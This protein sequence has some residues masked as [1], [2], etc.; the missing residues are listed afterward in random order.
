MHLP[1]LAGDGP[2]RAIDDADN[3]SCLS[4][5]ASLGML[6]IWDGGVQ[7]SPGRYAGSAR[8][9]PQ[10]A[11]CWAT[12]VSCPSCSRPGLVPLNRAGRS[13]HIA[14]Q[15]PITPRG[16]ETVYSRLDS[17]SGATSGLRRA[18]PGVVID[19]FLR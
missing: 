4:T 9:S 14:R 7:D 18:E 10:G 1:M 8:P 5:A 11:P 19:Q 17:E 3:G 2:G 13:G 12:R 15:A 16:G 6:V